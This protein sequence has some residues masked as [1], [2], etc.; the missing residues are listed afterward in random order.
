MSVAE[1]DADL[2]VDAQD[3]ILGRVASQVA[4]RGLEG[5]RVAIVNAERA[6][7]TGREEQVKEKYLERRGQTSDQGPAY[8]K[9]PDR[10]FKRAIRGMVPYKKPRGRQ[11]LENVRVYVG[12]PYADDDV[13]VDR[14]EDTSL[15]RLSNI[16][17]VSLGDVSEALGA[18]VTW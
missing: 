17:F 6:V 4:E 5:D 14:L 16:K 1:F 10:L 9:R 15:D 13:E 2:V 18:N 7:I 3:C 12:N 8:P 11:A